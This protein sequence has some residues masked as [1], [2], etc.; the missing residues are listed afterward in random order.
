MLF[1][2]NNLEKPENTKH[3]NKHDKY[4]SSRMDYTPESIVKLALKI[5]DI[6]DGDEVIDIGC[7]SGTFIKKAVELNENATYLGIDVDQDAIN[8]AW[9]E[10]TSYCNNVSFRVRDVFQKNENEKLYDKVFS[11]FPIGHNDKGKSD[12]DPLSVYLKSFR[13]KN[14]DLSKT[15]SIDWIYVYRL[16]EYL[17]KGGKAIG[18][19]STGS[20]VNYKDSFIRR[21]LIEN[22][23]IEA[24]ISF[25]P[26][27]LWPHT[28]VE[29]SMVVLSFGNTE[30]IRIVNAEEIFTEAR[31]NR[32][33]SDEN[34]AEIV[35][36]LSE[37]SE[38]SGF[39]K[40]DNLRENEYVLNLVKYKEPVI[41][42]KNAV[43]F[44][45]VILS[46]SRGAQL[47][48]ERCDE[49]IADKSKKDG[50]Y[51]LNLKNIED[52]VI[53]YDELEYLAEIEPRFEKY[54][55]ED[56]DLILAKGGYP[57][58]IAVVRK[59]DG[60]KIL[61]S[62][63]LYIIRL[64]RTKENPYYLKAFF[65]TETGQK[66]LK[67]ASVGSIIINIGVEQLKNLKIPMPPIEEQDAFAK[68]YIEKQNE[69]EEL[70][71]RIRNAKKELREMMEM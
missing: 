16:T 68:R 5:L 58:R 55:V 62:G 35:R 13:N 69:I 10:M 21:E 67:N 47:R 15:T 56:G 27:M 1:Y 64:D 30:G 65:E 37:D 39:V 61:P 42:F 20:A 33:L 50:I 43:P 17:K 18:I 11:N 29:T 53:R 3:D 49:L 40:I 31:R 28:F 41:P 12:N 19:V 46:V 36:L 59:K 32:E 70:K 51:Y 22:G 71:L 34:I 2:F 38:S 14:P 54:L 60:M 8:Q 45:G 7:G 26:K 44:Y 25:P 6:H 48:A 52:G 9:D 63:N 23:L 66:L 4:T 24:V 57:Y